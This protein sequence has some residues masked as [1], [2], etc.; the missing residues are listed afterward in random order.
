MNSK[1]CKLDWLGFTFKADMVNFVPDQPNCTPFRQF[2]M[3]FPEFDERLFVLPEFRTCYTNTM[4]YCDIVVS[5]NSFDGDMDHATVSRL[6]EMGVNVQVPSHCLDMFCQ[7]FDIDFNSEYAFRDLVKLLQERHCK[8]SRIDVCYDDYDK[9]FK[10]DYYILKRANNLIATPCRAV[11][12]ISGGEFGSTI[13]FGSL[14]KRNKL[15]RIYDKWAESGGEIDA[16]R[17]EFEYHAE[18]AQALVD[19]LFEFD[20]KLPFFE[21]L[22]AVCRVVD[23]SASYRL[24]QRRTDEEWNNALNGDLTLSCV[25]VKISPRHIDKLSSL[26]YYIETQAASSIAGYVKCFGR[27]ALWKLVSDAIRHGRISP[28]YQSY[29]NKLKY[30]EELNDCSNVLLDDNPFL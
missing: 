25:P 20:G 12:M 18:M 2:L 11:T 10:V 30:C 6:W 13:Y 1:F 8:F 15:L 22:I 5:F 9:L 16:V 3:M 19:K 28:R 24:S 7:M 23:S 26:N 17:Y 14:K 21:M 29:A 4:L 27:E